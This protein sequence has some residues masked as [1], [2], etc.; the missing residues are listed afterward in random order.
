[1]ARRRR[2][3]AG[4]PELHLGAE[5]KLDRAA[6]HHNVIVRKPVLRPGLAVDLDALHVVPLVQPRRGDA[7][8]LVAVDGHVQVREPRRAQQVDGLRHDRVQ[9]DELPQEPRVHGAGVAVP[10]DAVGGVFVAAFSLV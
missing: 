9:A 1:M 2:N 7:Q 3:L 6:V 8:R 4:L 10:G 5:L